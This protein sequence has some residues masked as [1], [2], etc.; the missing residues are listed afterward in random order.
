MAQG[1][2]GKGGH[3]IGW[4]GQRNDAKRCRQK[5]LMAARPIRFSQN[6]LAHRFQLCVFRDSKL[7]DKAFQ[8][9]FTQ[10]TKTC[11]QVLYIKRF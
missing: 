6:A 1:V 2:I 3:R 7:F 11:A 8:I 4:S 10:H 5:L 9:N